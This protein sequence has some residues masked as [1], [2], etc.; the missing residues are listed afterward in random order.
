[1]NIVDKNNYYHTILSILRQPN[2]EQDKAKL[3]VLYLQQILDELELNQEPEDENMNM[4]PAK[5]GKTFRRV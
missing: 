5:F 2:S 1:M 4:P 3:I